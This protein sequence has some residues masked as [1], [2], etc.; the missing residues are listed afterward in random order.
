MRYVRIND[1]IWEIV[2]QDE[3]VFRVK[4]LGDGHVYSKSKCTIGRYKLGEEISDLV[5]RYI[6]ISP[7]CSYKIYTRGQFERLSISEVNE[8]LK[9]GFRIFGAI[10][11]KSGLKYIAVIRDAERGL[12]LETL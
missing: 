3:R 5:N 11:T 6:T 10:W 8:K 4:A 9:S 7:R 12:E 1:T 2:D